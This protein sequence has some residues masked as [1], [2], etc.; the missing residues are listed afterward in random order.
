MQHS[1]DFFR[2]EQCTKVPLENEIKHECLDP[3]NRTTWFWP[4]SATSLRCDAQAPINIA[5]CSGV[6][7]SRLT[8]TDKN[9]TTT[10]YVPCGKWENIFVPTDRAARDPSMGLAPRCGVF[11]LPHFD[12]ARWLQTSLYEQTDPV[13]FG[14]EIELLTKSILSDAYQLFGAL[15]APILHGISTN[16]GDELTVTFDEDAQC[17]TGLHLDSWEGGSFEAREQSRTRLCINFGPGERFLLYVPLTLRQVLFCL[18][19]DIRAECSD[20]TRVMISEFFGAIPARQSCDYLCCPGTDI[21][22]IR[23]T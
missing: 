10:A 2:L 1:C 6:Q 3:S 9:Y 23:T 21:S 16:Q 22:P 5:R 12:Q 13:R 19:T 14:R 18:P 15:E 7:R 20:G 4:Q 8:A 17:Y 11:R